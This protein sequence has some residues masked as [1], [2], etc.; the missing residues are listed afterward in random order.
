MILEPF[1]TLTVF[2]L[3]AYLNIG[4]YPERVPNP[5]KSSCELEMEVSH[6]RKRPAIQ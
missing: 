5:S 4:K 2:I 3:I 6:K 1:G